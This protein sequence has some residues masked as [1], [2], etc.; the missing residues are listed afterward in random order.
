MGFIALKNVKR[1]RPDGSPTTICSLSCFRETV[2]GEYLADLLFAYCPYEKQQAAVPPLI[3]RFENFD[4]YIK[5]PQA[6]FEDHECACN[7]RNAC[8][9]T[10]TGAL[11]HSNSDTTLVWTRY[12][13]A[14]TLAGNVAKSVEVERSS[15]PS[16]VVDLIVRFEDSGS[17]HLTAFEIGSDELFIEAFSVHVT[18]TDMPQ[19]SN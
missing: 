4:I 14:L 17:L 8:V 7:D 12:K 19:E 9:P 13:P 10:T 6:P 5:K 18:E 11:V 16:G 2:V 3:I 15:P 1:V